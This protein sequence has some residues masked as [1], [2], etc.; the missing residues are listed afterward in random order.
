[1]EVRQRAAAVHYVEE[2]IDEGTQWVVF[3]PNDEP[4]GRACARWSR[5]F[6]TLVWRSGALHGA[7]EEQ[8]FFVRCD[9]TP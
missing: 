7:T 4:P 2:S 6:L 5:D 8:A 1:M 3:E 9:P